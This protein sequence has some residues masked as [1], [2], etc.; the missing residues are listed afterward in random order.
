MVLKL[1]KKLERDEKLRKFKNEIVSELKELSHLR[2]SQDL[3]EALCDCVEWRIKK[4]YKQDKK[5][6][7]LQILA[8]GLELNEEELMVVSNQIDYL[9]GKNIIKEVGTLKRIA[10]KFFFIFVQKHLSLP[11]AH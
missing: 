11:K 9:M 4:K 7:V 3:T 5:V 8:E 10:Y 6:L 1:G 2:L